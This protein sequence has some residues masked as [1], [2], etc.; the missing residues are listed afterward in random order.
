MPNTLEQAMLLDEAADAFK[1][2]LR[3]LLD[4]LQP[5]QQHAIG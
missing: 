5:Q 3:T 2:E 1:L 4:K